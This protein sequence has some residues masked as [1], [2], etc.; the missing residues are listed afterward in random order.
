[1]FISAK[2]R[3]LIASMIFLSCGVV[4][5]SP[6]VQSQICPSPFPISWPSSGPVWSLNYT[7]PD[8]SVGADGSGLQLTSVSYK[9]K[10]V[11]N[12]AHLPVLNVLYDPGGCGGT[13][14]SY[15]DWQNSL[16]DFDATNVVSTC[17]AEPTLPPTTVCDHPGS[18]VGTF[19]GVT[20]EKKS[21][22]LI[23]TTQMQAGWYRY[24]QKWFFFLDG[25]I[26]VRFYF[27]AITN[28]CVNKPHH[29]HAYWRL[30]FDIEGPANDVIEEF[31]KSTGW[32]ALSTEVNRKNGAGR[33]W[34]VRDKVT[35]RGYEVIPGPIDGIANSWAVADLWALRYH[36]TEIDD[37]GAT[38]GPT[39]NAVH[40]NNYLNSESIKGQDDVL[41]YRAGHRH[42]SAAV[43]I[44][45]G[46][47]LKPIGKW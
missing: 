3:V 34:R 17:K 4:F 29:H 47:T 24:I 5:D 41:W 10:R 22:Q 44:M 7:T 16:S 35:G 40:L 21:N 43:C 26:Q 30:D 1:M 2:L 37:G 31:N 25:T 8:N 9:G 28:Y 13:Y 6:V 36:T 33:K 27:T 20:V 18:D 15:R 32:T 46:P 19:S 23:L 12:T 39:G 11:F 14:L 38:T 45:V 42:E